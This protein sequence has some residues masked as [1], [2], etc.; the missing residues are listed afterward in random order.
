MSTLLA[1]IFSMTILGGCAPSNTDTGST[2]PV[3]LYTS[4]PG[5]G[6]E[7]QITRPEESIPA[8]TPPARAGAPQRGT[9]E[10]RS[11][12][13]PHKRWVPERVPQPSYLNNTPY[14]RR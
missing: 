12:T 2:L 13:R 5:C 9:V 8:A 6:L 14:G 7:A 10:R 11:A 4:T 1:M 3:G